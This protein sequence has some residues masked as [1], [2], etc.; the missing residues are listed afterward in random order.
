VNGCRAEGFKKHRV[1]IGKFDAV[2]AVKYDANVLDK[3]SLFD[4]YIFVY[5]AGP[6]CLSYSCPESFSIINGNPKLVP[7]FKL[8]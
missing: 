1:P 3:P 8:E 6:Q 2:A 4:M 7:K 5:T